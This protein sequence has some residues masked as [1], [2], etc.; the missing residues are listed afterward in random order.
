[1][2][3]IINKK[4]GILASFMSFWGMNT[5]ACVQFQAAYL[6][7]SG[8]G[9]GTHCRL[10]TKKFASYQANLDLSIGVSGSAYS[11]QKSLTWDLD[12]NASFDFSTAGWKRDLNQTLEIE[13]LN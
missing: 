6:E 3:N 12:V 7:K 13:S 8:K 11:C 9:L 4:V 10:F 2:Q 1:L 5:G